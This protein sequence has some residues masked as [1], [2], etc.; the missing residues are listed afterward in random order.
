MNSFVSMFRRFLSDEDGLGTV[1]IVII[2]AV[3]VGLAM[4]FRKQIFSFVNQIFERIFGDAGNVIG[5][6][7]ADELRDNVLGQGK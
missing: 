2:V 3:L 1:E 6:P 4:I 7:G 5:K